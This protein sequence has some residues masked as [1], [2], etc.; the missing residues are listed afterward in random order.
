MILVN[1]GDVLL[2]MQHGRRAARNGW[3]GKDMFIFMRPADDIDVT[4]VI[5]KVKSLPDSVK[6]YFSDRMTE[7]VMHARAN[8]T[9]EQGQQAG[10]IAASEEKIRFTPYLCMKAADG[11]I[12]NGWLASQTDMLSDDWV[13]L[14]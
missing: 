12:V 13:I 6:K 14:D 4:T 2:A 11:T 10:V 7:K 8:N 5:E 3:N 9:T 1:F